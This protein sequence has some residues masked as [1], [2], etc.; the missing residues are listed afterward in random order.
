YQEIGGVRG[1]LSQHAEATYTDLPSGEH[2]R[3]ARTLFLRLVRP[4]EAGQDPLRRRALSSE[5]ELEQ[6]E[7]SQV[8]Q[9]VIDTF[10]AARLI[11][12]SR[13]LGIST[14]EISHEALLREWPRLALW[15]REAREDM[16]LQER[17]ARD[18]HEW[19][20]KNKPKDYLYHGSQLKEMET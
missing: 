17:L 14:L 2:R 3:L 7:Q 11:T 19:E 1:A 4:G 20:Q 9:Q 8:L 15:V 10:L 12:S 6:A 5:F 13:K 16:Q 18:A